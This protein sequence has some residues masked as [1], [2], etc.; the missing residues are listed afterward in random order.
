MTRPLPNLTE[1]EILAHAARA[2]AIMGVLE[3]SHLAAP[4][5]I[6]AHVTE[7]GRVTWLV[8]LGERFDNPDTVGNYGAFDP[9][10]SGRGATLRE[11]VGKLMSK[12]EKRLAEL[13]ADVAAVVGGGA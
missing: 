13:A 12:L 11:A 6:E 2:R 9:F 3:T 4:M 1:P 5:R 10:Y 7:K 8:Y